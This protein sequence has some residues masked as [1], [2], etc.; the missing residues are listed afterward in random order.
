MARGIRVMSSQIVGQGHRKMVLTQGG[1]RHAKTINAIWFNA[2]ENLIGETAYA[3]LAFRLR[4]NHWNNNKSIQ[5]IIE[6]A[7]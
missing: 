2:D 3:R 4:W 6:D 7:Q 1:D 5:L